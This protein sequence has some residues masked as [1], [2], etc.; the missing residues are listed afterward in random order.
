MKGLTGARAVATPC[1][2]PERRLQ[3]RPAVARSPTARSVC[4]DSFPHGPRL[5]LAQRR[6]SAGGGL[7][8]SQ[9]TVFNVVH[10]LN[11]KNES[12]LNV[13]SCMPLR[14]GKPQVPRTQLRRGWAAAL[15]AAGVG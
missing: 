13:L 6:T 10:Y 5:E 15:G 2:A 14:G 12:F 4:L 11:N 1:A 9:F 3:P 7:V 8:C